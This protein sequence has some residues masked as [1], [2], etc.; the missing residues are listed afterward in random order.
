MNFA[1]FQKF[2]ENF[3]RER[4]DVID[5][6]ET[7]LYRTLARLIPFAPSVSSVPSTVHR[8]HL[9]SEWTERFGFPPETSRR[10]LISCGVRDSLS[11]LFQYGAGAQVALWIPKDNYPVYG[12][13]AR[14]AGFS[15]REFPTL[16]ETVWPDGPPAPG[17]EWL[18]VTNPLKPAGRF[19]AAQDVESLGRWLSA[20]PSRRLLLDAVYTFDTRFHPGTLALLES[21]RTILLHSLTKGWLH[22][23]LFGVALIPEADAAALTPAFRGDPPP[24]ENLA[25]ARNLMGTHAAM[26]DRVARSLASAMSRLREFLPFPAPPPHPDSTAGYFLTIQRSWRELLETQN[27][28]SLPATVFGSSREDLTVLSSLTFCA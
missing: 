5:C 26:P 12:E 28:L 9:A 19:L 22:P 24:Q 4:T 18:L 21:G 6:A 23:R 15:P 3:L 20:S 17:P 10:A 13:L 27:I 14:A 8:C 1:A 16:P 7:N 2:R 25:R 11:R